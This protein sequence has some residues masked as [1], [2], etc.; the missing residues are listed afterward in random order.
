[1]SEDGSEQP[2]GKG[3]EFADALDRI[4]ERVRLASTADSAAQ[5]AG[6]HPDAERASG[7]TDE[8]TAERLAELRIEERE[9]SRRRRQLHVRIDTLQAAPVPLNLTFS[10]QLQA[11]ERAEVVVSANRRRLHREIDALSASIPTARPG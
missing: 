9:L 11:F 5:V 1:M 8:E 7:E 6:M 10:A 2:G 3:T 4:Q